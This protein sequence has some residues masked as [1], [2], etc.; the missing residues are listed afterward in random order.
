MTVAPSRSTRPDRANRSVTNP[1]RH[2][3]CATTRRLS[4]GPAFRNMRLMVGRT[5]LVRV[6]ALLSQA[7]QT[8][9]AISRSSRKI[10]NGKEPEHFRKASPRDGEKEKGRGKTGAATKEKATS[11]RADHSGSSGSWRCGCLRT[12]IRDSH[13]RDRCRACCAVR[14][15]NELSDDFLSTLPV[16]S[17]SRLVQRDLW[18]R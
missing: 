8:T 4:V 6:V 16:H 17:S 12:A 3:A 10:I 13:P 9:F 18:P 11:R 1:P 7:D 2:A 14:I 5:A 15:G